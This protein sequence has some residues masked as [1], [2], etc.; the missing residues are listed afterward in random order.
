[1]HR[2]HHPRVCPLPQMNSHT[3]DMIIFR[4]DACMSKQNESGRVIYYNSMAK[5]LAATRDNQ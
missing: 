3:E 2:T 4:L 5:L 1:M